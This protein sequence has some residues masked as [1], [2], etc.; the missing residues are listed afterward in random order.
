ML[1]EIP[2]RST[3]SRAFDE[4]ARGQLPQLAH[5]H[6]VKKHLGDRLLG[7]VSIDAT[8]IEAREAPAKKAEKPKEPKPAK[9]RGRRPKDQEPEPVVP[10]RLELQPSRTLEENLAD[11]PSPCDVGT[12]RNSQGSDILISY[13]NLTE[14]PERRMAQI[15]RKTG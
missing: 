7:H 5:E 8:A 9:K 1:R 10:K 3:F 12:K 11:L 2:E 15:W 6:I 4:F 13:R 14:I